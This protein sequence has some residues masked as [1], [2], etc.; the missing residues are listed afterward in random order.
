MFLNNEISEIRILLSGQNLTN[1]TIFENRLKTFLPSTNWL[2][3]IERAQAEPV[4]PGLLLSFSNK[5]YY[6]TK[7]RA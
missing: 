3:E 2:L 7:L 5:D 1:K 6:P 4:S